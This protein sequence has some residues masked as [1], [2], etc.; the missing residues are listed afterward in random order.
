[1]TEKKT[2]LPSLRNQDSKNVEVETEKVNKLLPNNPTGNITEVKELI[3]AGSKSV[4]DIIVVPLMNLN[5]YTKAGRTGKK[6][7]RKE[8]YAIVSSNDKLKKQQTSLSMQLEEINQK[9]LAKEGRLKRYREGSINTKTE[10]SK[11]MNEIFTNK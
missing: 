1:M 8:K 9:I 6:V 7:R 11:I 3:Y 10:Y 5:K 4:C 2:I